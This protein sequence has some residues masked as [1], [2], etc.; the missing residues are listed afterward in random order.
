M[1]PPSDAHGYGQPSRI[2]LE[3]LFEQKYGL[4][5]HTGWSPRQRYGFGYYLPADV[6]EALIARI[7]TD[8]CRWLDVGGGH[9][10][11]PDNPSLSRILAA[12]AGSVVAVDPSDNVQANPYVHERVQSMLEDYHSAEPFDVASLR[13]VAEHVTD[14][15]RL[16]G[17]LHRLVRPGGIVVVFTV[18]ARSPLTLLSRAIPFR[19]HHPI[20]KLFW[21]GE[22]EDTFPVEYRMNSRA[23]LKTLFESGGFQEMSF[24]YLDDLSTFGQFRLGSYLELV[25]WRL[26]NR[27]GLRYPENCLLGVYRKRPH[28]AA[29]HESS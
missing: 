28:G 3:H 16:V 11:F 10:I 27:A 6:Y 21:G 17:A 1:E 14:P 9:H 12:R 13:M 29:H 22:E 15:I 18:N 25:W 2:E 19:F 8:G 23:T 7:I 20:K 26:L 5:S 4:P 24:T